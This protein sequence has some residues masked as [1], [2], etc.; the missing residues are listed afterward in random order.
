M[1][2]YRAAR[3]TRTVIQ[4][5]A[6]AAIAASLVLG[7]HCL[8]ARLQFGVAVMAFSLFWICL[9][10]G[11][12]LLFGRIYCSTV[13]PMGALMDMS[14]WLLRKKNAYFKYSAAQNSL[15]LAFLAAVVIC[16]VFGVKS[17][18]NIFEPYSAFARIITACVRPAAISLS[19]L[20][21]AAATAVTVIAFAT[22]RGRLLCNTAC[23]VGT[24]LAAPARISLYHPDINTD[25]CTGCGICA[26]V[27]PSECINL[28][29]HTVD[30][31]RCVVCF[32][33]MDRCPAGAITYRRGRHQLS[34]PLL[35]Q[36]GCRSTSGVEAIEKSCQQDSAARPIDRRTF[37]L[38]GV[39][40]VAAGASHLAARTVPGSA[41]LHAVN[42]VT[43][44]GTQSRESYFARCTACDA[45]IAACPSGVLTTAYREYGI[46]NMLIPVMDFSKSFCLYDC[47]KCTEVCPTRALTPITVG[48]KHT[49]VIGQARIQASNCIM[50]THG[51]A[52]GICVRRCPRQAIRII[53]TT[54]GRRCPDVNPDICIGCGQCSYACPSEPYKAIV[55]EGI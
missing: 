40:A 31:S 35:Q 49:L 25:L 33:C 51:E 2:P 3:I 14:A 12:T 20:I 1:K 50:Y 29:S 15:R 54:D 16:G 36:V 17:F 41:R 53:T 19:G 6:V 10:L 44:P 55:I 45:C 18:V 26:D 38:T 13:C 27:C 8:L 28:D 30:S 43:P 11:V 24:I 48:E 5:I 47:V 21:V 9:W 52:C 32:K 46:R 37:L 39:L 4:S 23:P 34:I 22:R 7:I 42:S